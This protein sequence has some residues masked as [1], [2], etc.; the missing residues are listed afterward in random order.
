MHEESRVMHVG[1]ICLQQG[2]KPTHVP[3][4]REIPY[5]PCLPEVLFR[6]CRLFRIVPTFLLSGWYSIVLIPIYMGS[7]KLR[8]SVRVAIIPVVVR[9]R[10]CDAPSYREGDISS[11]G[12]TP[13]SP[14]QST[15]G[16]KNSGFRT[17]SHCS[18]CCP[19][20]RLRCSLLSRG[21]YLATIGAEAYLEL[22]AVTID[23][24][25]AWSL[26]RGC[27]PL[28]DHSDDSGPMAATD[29]HLSDTTY[30]IAFVH[31]C[32][33]NLVRDTRTGGIGHL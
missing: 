6:M 9:R 29:A 26:W 25:H 1:V 12:L 31:M 15:W 18:R 33:G 16:L 28:G 13:S 8:A 20:S 11:S 4:G 22:D 5:L 7:T 21:R 30:A 2:W 10:A 24:G 19:S 3:D 23:S 17:C 32:P 27:L 14:S